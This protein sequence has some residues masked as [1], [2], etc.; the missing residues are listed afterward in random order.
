MEDTLPK[1]LRRNYLRYGDKKV[2]M[3][4]KDLGIWKEY[5]WKDVYEHVKWVSLGLVSLGLQPGDNVAIVGDS[6]PSGSGLNMPLKRRE[7]QP[8][9]YLWMLTIL[10]L[11]LLSVILMPSL[12]SPRTRNRWIRF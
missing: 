5:T 2:A 12:P 11:N 10:R 3:R 7:G 1:I 8:Q 6:D 9:V 4:K